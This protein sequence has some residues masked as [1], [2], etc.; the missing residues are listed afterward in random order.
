MIYMRGNPNDFNQWATHTGDQ[1]WAYANVEKIFK[2]IEDYH[3]YWKD[4]S[5]NSKIKLNAVKN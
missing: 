3:G 5:T 4:T 2:R 1:R